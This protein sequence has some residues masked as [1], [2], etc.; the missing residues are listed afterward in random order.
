MIMYLPL[1]PKDLVKVFGWGAPAW[2]DLKNST[3]EYEFEDVNYD[4]FHIYDYKA[5]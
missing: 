3:Y 5:T 2:R 4:V 1:I